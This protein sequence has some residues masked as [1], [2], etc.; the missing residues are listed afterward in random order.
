MEITS[1]WVILAMCLVPVAVAAFAVEVDELEAMHG[2]W[3][4]KHI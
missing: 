4:Q 2:G 1:F 3:H